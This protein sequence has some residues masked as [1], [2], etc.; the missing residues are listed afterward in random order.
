VSGHASKLASLLER[1]GPIILDGGLGSELDRRGFDLSSLLWSAEMLVD[2]PQAIID[3]HR[4]YLDAGAQCITSASYQASI[5]GFA[6][7]GLSPRQSKALLIKSVELARSA[8]DE[9]VAQN[10]GCG[11]QPLIA[12][13]IGPYGAFL[14]DGSEYRGDYN[15]DDQVLLE[16]HQQRLTWLDGAGADVLACETIP[17]LQEAR[18]LSQLL[19]RVST[20]AWVSFSC[21]NGRLLND[22]STLRQAVGL[23]EFVPKVIGIGVNCTA[24]QFIQSLI[25]EIKSTSWQRAVVVYPNSGEHYD[26]DRNT[27][28]GTET[29]MECAAAALSWYQAGANVIGGCCRMGPEHINEIATGFDALK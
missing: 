27:W 13:S 16:F 4:T 8:V 25:G 24:P 26:A 29:P 2:N 17:G 3:I 14:A 11:Y 19:E 22:G 20:D 7:L 18:V 1:D 6:K 10:P 9:Y 5:A 28:Y 15:V 12:A 23:F 21:Q